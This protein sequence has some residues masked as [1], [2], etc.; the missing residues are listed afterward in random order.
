MSNQRIEVFLK[1][2]EKQKLAFDLLDDPTI[3]ELDYGGAAGGAKSW[4]VALWMVKQ[5]REYPGI[6]VPYPNLTLPT[7]NSA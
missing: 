2:S 3:V 5:C 1:L 6:P 4:T 7:I